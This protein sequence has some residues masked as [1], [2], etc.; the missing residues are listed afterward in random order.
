MKHTMLYAALLTPFLSACGGSSG[1]DSDTGDTGGGNPLPETIAVEAYR[2]SICGA[3]T[4]AANVD[5]IAHQADGSILR[6]VK[7]GPD[8]KAELT[9]TSAAHLTVAGQSVDE[10]GVRGPDI[11][12]HT[13]WRS[14]DAG[15]FGFA[16][17]TDRQGCSCATVSLDGTDVLSQ[18][19]GL[20]LYYTVRL[21]GYLSTRPLNSNGASLELCA[22]TGQ[23]ARLDLVLRS[24]FGGESYGASLEVDVT[25]DT[26]VNLDPAMFAADKNRGELVNLDMNGDF[27][28]SYSFA[29]TSEGRQ[30]SYYA[31]PGEP[32][33]YFPGLY[34]HNLAQ[35][36]DYINIGAVAEGSV[37][38]QRGN[39]DRIVDGYVALNLP[40][41]Q[42]PFADEALRVLEGMMEGSPVSGYDFRN[43]G[44]GRNLLSVDIAD[45]SSNS[46]WI[47]EAPLSGSM[48]ALALP[49]SYL[50][51]LE[52]MA[53]PELRITSYGYH[54]NLD[55]DRF[56]QRVVALGQQGGA[57]DAF[58]D[59]YVYESLV[60]SLNP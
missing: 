4:P 54:Q 17:L 52:T 48:P 27:I 46:R 12:T 29:E 57:R 33:F 9:W 51:Q 50:A 39:R 3:Q 25:S 2:Y 11:Y 34:Q 18:Y 55:I 7:T 13:A 58:F 24:S 56:R 53:A 38:Y 40:T 36:F 10:F 45:R 47:V 22:E 16:D 21:P 15:R 49:E 1:S 8:G 32:L 26:L 14:G 19:S 44:E 23:P 30:H 42:Q 37:D 43:I 60:I 41:T 59:R 35:A 28:V 20:S 5:V 31:Y 6:S